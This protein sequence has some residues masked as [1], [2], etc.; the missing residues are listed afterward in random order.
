VTT[1][2]WVL[3]LAGYVVIA[4]IT[5][6]RAAWAFADR[7]RFNSREQ[8]T[9]FEIIWGLV[10]GAA[11]ASVWPLT[12]AFY[13]LRTHGIPLLG[14]RFLLPPAHIRLEQQAERIEEQERRI[15]EL[16]RQTEIH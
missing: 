3:L 2:F 6:R 9:T 10:V 11:F 12:L 1:V 5:W 13:A 4:T 16:E 14:R 8:F 15:A 7:E